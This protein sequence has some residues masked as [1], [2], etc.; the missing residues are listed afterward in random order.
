[1]GSCVIENPERVRF[2]EIVV[3]IYC[4]GGAAF[5]APAAK[6]A[7]EALSQHFRR[8][9]AVILGF[10]ADP[11]DGAKK[12]FFEAKGDVPGV[13]ITAEDGPRGKVGGVKRILQAAAELKA[14]AVA[15]IDPTCEKI[16]PRQIKQLL[17]PVLE[18]FDYVV[19]FYFSRTAGD[20]FADILAYPLVRILYGLRIRRSDAGC[21]GISGRLVRTYLVEKTWP[22]DAGDRGVDIWRTVVSAARGFRVCQTFTDH[23]CS[24]PAAGFAEMMEAIFTTAIDFEY[25]WKSVSGSRPVSCFGL[26]GLSPVG[27]GLEDFDAGEVLRAF[28]DGRRE[29][30][31]AWEKVLS[32]MNIADLR[33]IEDARTD[34][35]VF[36][37]DLWARILFDFMLAYRD[38]LLKKDE[39][40][41][42]LF[43]LYQLRALSC[44]NGITRAKTAGEVEEFIEEE[45]EKMER[46]RYYLVARWDQTPRKD[47]REP[48]SQYFS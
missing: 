36:G 26:P 13:Y 20:L 29:H 25:F 33:S 34:G 30:I 47:G 31:S 48:V 4:R 40:F 35:V 37:A 22:D 28:R 39:I 7:G 23:Y 1:M 32:P 19:P 38:S 44:F 2:A 41:D 45:C 46:E 16:S 12:A 6:A 9:D 27:S 42:S 14:T 10:D 5:M 8:S 43:L 21:C 3:S 17:E 11:S 18:G 24:S 15:I